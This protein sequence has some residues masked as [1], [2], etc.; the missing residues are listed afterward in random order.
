MNNTLKGILL[1]LVLGTLWG[2]IFG[3]YAHAEWFN[4]RS[5]YSDSSNLKAIRES[6]EELNRHVAELV[7]IERERLKKE[8]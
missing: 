6:L 2:V 8:D 7:E 3:P 4:A 5:P 1:A